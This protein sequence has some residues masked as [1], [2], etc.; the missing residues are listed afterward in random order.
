MIISAKSDIGKVRSENQDRYR[1][2]EI[3]DES[4]FVLVCDGMG[5]ANG[6]SIASE[7]AANAIYERV[8]LSYRDNMEPK[9]VKNLLISAVT[10][11]NTIVYNKSREE[12][13]ECGGMGTTCVAALI[14]SGTLYV[15]SVG[16]SRGYILDSGGI[17]QITKDHTVTEMYKEQNKQPPPG[18]K[19]VITRAVGVESEVQVDYFEL[20]VEKGSMLV[21]CTDG[22]TNYVSDELL[23]AMA[24]KH[25]PVDAVEELVGYANSKGG[26][27]NITAVAVSI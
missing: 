3:N 7:T 2:G 16:D 19:N 4:V 6:G 17:R 1:V 14:H 22:L 26:K 20:T 27:D 25:A 11:A 10:A 12:P 21:L 13:E 8:F 23:Y 9:T 18:T 5:G 15:V 24:Y